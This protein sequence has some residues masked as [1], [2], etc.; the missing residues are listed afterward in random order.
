MTETAAAFA[1][2]GLSL[3]YWEVATMIQPQNC[4]YH[5]VLVLPKKFFLWLTLM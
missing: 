5:H 4:R 2:V 1:N 3:A